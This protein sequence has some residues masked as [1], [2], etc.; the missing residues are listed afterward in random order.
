MAIEF[1]PTNQ[2]VS[3]VK[4]LKPV[5]LEL[6]CFIGYPFLDEFRLEEL[7]SCKTVVGFIFV[8][9]ISFLEA[10]CHVP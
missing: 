5:K 7:S 8:L 1:L 2:Y 4:L 6:D 10:F 9:Y 3:L